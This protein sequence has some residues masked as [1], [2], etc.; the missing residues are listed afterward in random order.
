MFPSPDWLKRPEPIVTSFV[1]SGCTSPRP[2]RQAARLL[3]GCSAWKL[4][5]TSDDEWNVEETERWERQL[6]CSGVSSPRR[7]GA[8]VSH[9]GVCSFFSF[10]L[11]F[12]PPPSHHNHLLEVFALNYSKR[13]SIS[14]QMGNALE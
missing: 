7:W 1:P 8:T 6:L 12:P 11:C 4:P 3:F 13:F 9:T 10:F 5:Q 14:V 2:S